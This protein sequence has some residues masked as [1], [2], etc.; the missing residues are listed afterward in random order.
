MAAESSVR[1]TAHLQGAH[2]VPLGCRDSVQG[3]LA[4]PVT[5]ELFARRGGVDHDGGTGTAT[6]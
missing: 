4:L 5:L 2:T 6:C 1:V 3:G